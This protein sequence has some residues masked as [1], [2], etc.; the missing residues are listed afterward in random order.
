[1][2]NSPLDTVFYNIEKAIKIYRRMA[3]KNLNKSNHKITID[4]IIVLWMINKEEINSQVEIAKL[5][6]KDIASI[7]RII[8][9]LV[10]KGYLERRFHDTDRRRYLLDVTQK[11]QK[12]LDEA[13]SIVLENRT[14]ALDGL[15]AA[16]I[17]SLN[18]ILSKIINNCQKQ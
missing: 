10:K 5:L 7:T 8:E 9:L 14:K 4:Q 17:Q 1:M 2:Q 13:F 12:V 11:G 6:F 3:Q 15:D 16:E 18:Q